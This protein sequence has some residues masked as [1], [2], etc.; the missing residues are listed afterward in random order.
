MLAPGVPLL[1]MGEEYGEVAPF[2]YFIDHG[3]PELVAA[4]RQGRAREFPEEG[5]DGTRFD[6]ADPATMDAA[7]LDHS[8]CASGDHAELQELNR[9]LIALRRSVPALRR[10]PR[11][12]ARAS[13][14]GA[15]ITLIR[16]H[17]T[18]SVT[19]LF[20]LSA[21]E[22]S[23]LLPDGGPWRDLFDPDAPDGASGDAVVMDPWGFRLFRLGGAAQ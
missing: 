8:L 15:V 16:A 20:N 14:A 18:G 23:A 3:D 11:Q 1:F 6:P 13:A 19:A 7:L 5:V 17:T 2:P 4:V 21:T 12:A 9:T 10:S 22:T